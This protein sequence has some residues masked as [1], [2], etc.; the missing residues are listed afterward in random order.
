MMRIKRQKLL[1]KKDMRLKCSLIILLFLLAGCGSKKQITD[2]QKGY[3]LDQVITEESKEN[4]TKVSS[5]DTTKKSSQNNE[6][7]EFEI[8][9]KTNFDSAGNIQSIETNIKGKGSK[10]NNT[11]EQKGLSSDSSA[12]NKYNLKS[13]SISKDSTEVDNSS[14]IKELPKPINKIYNWIGAAFFLCIGG[15]FLWKFILKK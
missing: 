15:F 8:N 6:E 5:S 9:T 14:F 7:Y 11:D 12:N 13:D 2:I 4:T 3:S 10:N 1:I